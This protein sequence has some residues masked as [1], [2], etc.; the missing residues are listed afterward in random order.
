MRPAAGESGTV[1]DDQR[2]RVAMGRI[3]FG[4]YCSSGSNTGGNRASVVNISLHLS[5]ST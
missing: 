5:G 2:G 1:D 3:F 4:A